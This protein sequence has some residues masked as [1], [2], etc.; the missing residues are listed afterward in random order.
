MSERS[1]QIYKDRE[2]VQW[3]ERLSDVVLG[4]EGGY[5]MYVDE[6]GLAQRVVVGLDDELTLQK[7]G[8][9]EGVFLRAENGSFGTLAV[10]ADSRAVDVEILGTARLHYG[11][12][13]DG[14][15]VYKNGALMLSTESQAVDVTIQAGAY[16]WMAGNSVLANSLLDGGA[17]YSLSDC[18]LKDCTL[19]GDGRAL[20][21]RNVTVEGTFSLM[22]AANELNLN[23]EKATLLFRVDACAPESTAFLSSWMKENAPAA[24]GVVISE[25]QSS[26]SYALLGDASGF[27][28]TLSV[29]NTQGTA[30]GA[31]FAG[32]TL[33]T[34]TARYTLTAQGTLTFSVDNRQVVRCTLGT[35]QAIVDGGWA[36]LPD[37]ICLFVHDGST[38]ATVKRGDWFAEEL[39]DAQVQRVAIAQD[40][41]R[42]QAAE[43]IAFFQ[44]APV[45]LWGEDYLAWNSFTDDRCAMAGKNRFAD[46]FV[47]NG[48]ASAALLLTD[49]ADAL[50]ADDIYSAFAKTPE[51]RL[52]GLSE[53]HAGAGD[54]LVDLTCLS[55]PAEMSGCLLDGG[56]GNDILWGGTQAAIFVGGDGDDLMVAHRDQAIFAFGDDWGHDTVEVGAGLDFRLWFAADTELSISYNDFG[57][58]LQCGENSVSVLGVFADIEEKILFGDAV[59]VSY[60]GRTGA[61]LAAWL[62]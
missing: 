21:G 52:Q 32:E 45:G 26:G 36:S 53:I 3:G 34:D 55:I 23:L 58:M 50:F 12:L 18:R 25:T 38:T 9:A 7:G 24:S 31:L 6:D 20:S 48:A 54:D 62:A 47:G 43:G 57:A 61:S 8:V 59:G 41:A 56:E 10:Y 40:P 15:N 35:M 49:Q 30:L 37:K 1:V 60:A 16:L 46:V 2:L 5:A 29:E 28:Q 22:G 42:I 17:S 19:K 51:N 4:D 11:G 13:L 14:G 39:Q 44:A 27:R 33:S